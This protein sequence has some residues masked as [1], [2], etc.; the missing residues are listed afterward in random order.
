[1]TFP[2]NDIV[3]RVTCFFFSKFVHESFVKVPLLCFVGDLRGVR[4]GRIIK[5]STCI[6]SR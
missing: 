3:T 5:I 4:I 2:I 1:M 6:L